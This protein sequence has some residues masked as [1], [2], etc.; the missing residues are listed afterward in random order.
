MVQYRLR[1]LL[2]ARARA[3]QNE[4][5]AIMENAT[6]SEG[7]QRK[8]LKTRMLTYALWRNDVVEVSHEQTQCDI[9][10]KRRGE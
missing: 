9:R 7:Y 1:T 3:G 6:R 5:T 4:K 10:G 2:Q 8:V